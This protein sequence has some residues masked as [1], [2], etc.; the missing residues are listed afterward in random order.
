[1][2]YLLDP[3]Y[4]PDAEPRNPEHE[5][6]FGDLQKFRAARLLVPVDEDHLYFAAMRSKACRLT[7]TGRFYWNLAN[8]GKL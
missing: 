5:A 1:M 2:D 4:E 6:I 8:G 7:P 3:S